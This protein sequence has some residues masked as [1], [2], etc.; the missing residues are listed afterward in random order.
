MLEP[1]QM[2]APSKRWL[3]LVSILFVSTATLAWSFTRLRQPA[4]LEGAPAFKPKAVSSRQKADT[5]NGAGAI[6]QPISP[7]CPSCP[8]SPL[9]DSDNDGIPDIEELRTYQDRDSF[10]R[11]FTAIAELQF[12]QPSSQWNAEQ[13]DCAGLVRFAMR[14]ALRRHDRI[15]FQKMG[16][17]YETVASDVGEFDLDNNPL[18]EKIFRT[19]FGSFHESDLRNGRFSEFA[20]GRSLKNFNSFFVTRD[21]REAQPGDLL[22]FYQ[23]WVQKFPYHVMILL[24]PA[25]VAQNGAPDWVVYHTGSSPGDKGTVKKVELSVLDHHPDPRWRPLESNK[26]FLGFYRLKILQ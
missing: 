5:R 13:R 25:R 14:E 10:R 21:R 22:F 16:P 8:S 1:L 19:D 9:V 23:P 4:K 15:W 18:G 2:R 11:W 12:Y 6:D 17:G 26:N 24:G 3:A 20:D 7:P